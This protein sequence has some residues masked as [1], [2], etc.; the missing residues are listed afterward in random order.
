MRKENCAICGKIVY[1]ED[2]KEFEWAPGAILC[3]KH[4]KFY[5][6]EHKPCCASGVSGATCPGMGGDADDEDD[7]DYD[8]FE[9]D[10]DPVDD[11]DPEMDL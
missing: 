3:S 2:G 4:N 8:D 6:A 5:C 10:D 9:D 11:E 1:V 7:I